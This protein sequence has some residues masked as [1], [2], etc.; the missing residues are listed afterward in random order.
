[1]KRFIAVLLLLSIGC[2][3]PTGH[4]WYLMSPPRIDERI[5]AKAPLSTW[6]I[7]QSFDSAADCEAERDAD[8]SRAKEDYEHPKPHP[9]LTI[10]QGKLVDL[11]FIFGKCIAT[12]DPRLA[13]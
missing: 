2:S 10:E 11:Q 3:K 8:I 13:K 7:Q 12:D 4:G 1:M 9:N 5:D 6:K